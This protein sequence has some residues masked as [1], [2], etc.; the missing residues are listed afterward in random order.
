MAA[1]KDASLCRCKSNAVNGFSC[2]FCKTIYHPSCAKKY[3]IPMVDDFTVNC[4]VETS[5]KV[6]VNNM[7]CNDPDLD[8][9]HSDV[10]VRNAT[11]SE[12]KEI[13]YLKQ[14]LITKDGMISNLQDYIINLKY[15][16]KLLEERSVPSNVTKLMSNKQTGNCNNMDDKRPI[17][18]TR[19][20]KNN[21]N[22]TKQQNLSGNNKK[23]PKKHLLK[24]ASCSDEKQLANNN[25]ASG[26]RTINTNDKRVKLQ[27]SGNNKQ[28]LGTAKSSSNLRSAQKM[29]H[30]YLSR[31][32][33]E[34]KP[35]QITAYLSKF[36]AT[37]Q[38]MKTDEFSCA[39][40]VDYPFEYHA[41]IFNPELWPENCKIG[42]YYTRNTKPPN[43]QTFA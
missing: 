36:K 1:A 35:E 32:H 29:G 41:E 38:L 40:K 13:Y 39:F 31:M 42:R 26:S 24:S 6:I 3:K 5:D 14:L 18:S 25:I 27:K 2:K 37:C 15:T 28:L 7:V 17:L 30:M 43:I 21:S 10:P 12:S 19:N 20:D 9:R 34:T 16:I 4:C 23:V 33:C 11:I 22:T 8:V